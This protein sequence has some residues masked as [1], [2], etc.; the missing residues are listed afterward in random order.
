[1][2]KNYRLN[3][4]DPFCK[5][6]LIIVLQIEI[7]DVIKHV[8]TQLFCVLRTYRSQKCYF[9]RSFQFYKTTNENDQLIA[10]INYAVAF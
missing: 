5:L 4:S 6:N 8:A 9:Y 7:F 10:H 3:R 1:M 2:D